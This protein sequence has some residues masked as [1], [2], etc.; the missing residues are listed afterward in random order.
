LRYAILI[1]ARLASTRLADKVLLAESGKP[2]IQHV[3]EQ[4][5]RAPGVA[6]VVVLTDH[7]RIAEAVRGFGGEVRMTRAD[8]PSGTDRCAEGAADLDVDVVV[9]LQ[10]DEP[11]ASPEDLAALAEAV[12]RTGADIATLGASFTSEADPADPSAVKAVRDEAHWALGFTRDLG[13]ARD[14]AEA[15]RGEVLH[16]LGIYAFRRARL[17]AFPGL[18]PTAGEQRERLEQLRAL[19]H[20]WRIQVLDASVP[21]FGIDTRED[22]EAFLARLRGPSGD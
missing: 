19:E 14:L 13:R 3:H 20:G 10:G 5:A 4:A 16:H 2:L 8:H 21:A 6:A 11:F 17:L 7:E 22:Y 15:D 1:P 12:A 18:A 9:N